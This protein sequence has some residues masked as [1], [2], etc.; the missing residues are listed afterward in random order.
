MHKKI[1][2]ALL[3]TLAMSS[4]HAARVASGLSS[5]SLGG[6]NSLGLGFSVVTAGQNDLNNVIDANH[7]ANSAS[8]KNLGSAYEFYAN[9]VYRFDSSS[10]AF[11]LRP[12]Y[13][14]QTETGSGTGGNYD[15]K[16]NGFAVF[17]IIRVYPLES[18]FI[19]FFMQA[20]V[21][22]GSLSGDITAGANNLTFKGSAFGAMGGIGVDFCFTESHCITVEGNLR[23]L[24]IERNIAE[25]NCTNSSIS[26]INQCSNGKEV[27]T[28]S[29]TD[30]RTTM[31]GVQ[32]LIGYTMNF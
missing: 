22:Y 6:T 17:P 14:T 13:F 27:E 2:V 5:R 12:S 24:P 32:G 11:V 31:S 20:G 19:H 9:W 4:A 21:G 15:F 8:T 7:T 16:L 25:G 30:L 28:S 1:F 26:G 3:C 10:V 29:D 18:P 23:Y